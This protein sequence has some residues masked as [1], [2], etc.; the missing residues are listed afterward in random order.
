MADLIDVV[1]GDLESFA[2]QAENLG[3]D[4]ARLKVGA[5]IASIHGTMPGARS[6]VSALKAGEAVERRVGLRASEYRDF[7]QKVSQARRNFAQIDHGVEQ[8]MHAVSGAFRDAKKIR[9]R[10]GG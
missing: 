7:S 8:S 1:H 6:A 3:D 10:L 5:C 4:L 2:S 9:E